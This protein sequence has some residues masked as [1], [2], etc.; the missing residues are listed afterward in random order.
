MQCF[1]G[2]RRSGKTWQMICLSHDTGFPIIAR[3]KAMAN[4]IEGQ[5]YRMGKT[6]PKPIP[7]TNYSLMIGALS[8]EKV[9][10]DESQGIL[11]DILKVRIVAASIDGEALMLPLQNPAIGSLGFIE[12]LRTWIKERRAKREG[13]QCKE[14]N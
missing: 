1:V 13:K 8:G 5:A 14:E 11:E 7:A 10:V 9:I 3:T 2:G 12:L 6:I 4:Y